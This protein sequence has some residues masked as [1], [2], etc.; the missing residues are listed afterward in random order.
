MYLKMNAPGLQKIHYKNKKLKKYI[1]NFIYNIK[2][3]KKISTYIYNTEMPRKIDISQM[4]PDEIVAYAE[5][6]KQQNRDRVKKHYNNTIKTDPERY[7]AWLQQCREANNRQ[8]Y[9]RIATREQQLVS[10]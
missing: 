5:K 8:Y 10:A 7:E 6:V 1:Q 2:Q 3:L 9:K 4:T